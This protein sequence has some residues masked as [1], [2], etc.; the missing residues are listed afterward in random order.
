MSKAVDRKIQD[1]QNLEPVANKYQGDLAAAGTSPALAKKVRE[2]VN[3][4][5]RM[6]N[7]K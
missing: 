7:G 1:A 5:W 2:M 4:K 3:V 6:E